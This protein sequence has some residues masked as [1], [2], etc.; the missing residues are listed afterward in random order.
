M[1]D[2]EFKNGQ[3]VDLHSA[4]SLFVIMMGLLFY[5]DA[6]PGTHTVITMVMVLFGIAWYLGHKSYIHWRQANAHNHR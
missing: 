5:I 3:K 2:R 1:L 4:F 6:A